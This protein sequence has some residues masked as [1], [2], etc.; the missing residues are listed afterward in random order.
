MCCVALNE[1]HKSVYLFHLIGKWAP[2]CFEL[3][4]KGYPQEAHIGS[5]RQAG[6]DAGNLHHVSK[7]D[8]RGIIF[9]LNWGTVKDIMINSSQGGKGT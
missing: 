7:V 9:A 8:R 4:T 6:I 2:L 5:L 3:D 1:H